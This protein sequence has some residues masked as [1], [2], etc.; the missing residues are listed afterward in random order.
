MNDFKE[1]AETKCPVTS[2]GRLAND[3]ASDEEMGGCPMG[4]G[5]KVDKKNGMPE[6]YGTYLQVGTT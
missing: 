4:Q 1:S 5:K 6:S 3:G 2:N